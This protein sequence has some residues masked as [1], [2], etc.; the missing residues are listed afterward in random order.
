M[1]DIKIGS[2]ETPIILDS[3]TPKKIP[4]IFLP[5]SEVKIW[6]IETIQLI[7]V[8]YKWKE[9]TL[10]LFS[11]I[12]TLCTANF[13]EVLF[14]QPRDFYVIVF[15]AIIAN[16][17]WLFFSIKKAIKSISIDKAIDQLESK[18]DKLI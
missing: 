6:L 10:L 12:F 5:R 13:K 2:S 17:V 14:F 8:K 3:K 4:S 9:P 11:L 7:D 1:E 16:A 18:I 15:L